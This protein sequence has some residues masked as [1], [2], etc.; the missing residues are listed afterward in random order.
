MDQILLEKIVEKVKD[1]KCPIHNEIAS[2]EIYK[3]GIV[4][5]NFCC[6]DFYKNLT[7]R[8]QKELDLGL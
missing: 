5:K 3:G 8:I 7:T 6:S 1:K 2:F 4:I